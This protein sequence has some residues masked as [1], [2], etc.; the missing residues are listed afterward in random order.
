[1]SVAD[2]NP[3]CSSCHTPAAKS[4]PDKQ[5][6]LNWLSCLGKKRWCLSSVFIFFI[7]VHGFLSGFP[8]CFDLHCPPSLR[9]VCYFFCM[10]V[11][12]WYKRDLGA[13][14][15]NSLSE[16]HPPAHSRHSSQTLLTSDSAVA[17]A[18]NQQ[19]HFCS[20]WCASTISLWRMKVKPLS[21]EV[22]VYQEFWPDSTATTSSV[23][24]KKYCRKHKKLI[25][26]FPKVWSKQRQQNIIFLRFFL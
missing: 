16:W 11:S 26:A 6:H 7:C 18:S 22:I 5:D 15:H 3:L 19:W 9:L 25:L 21:L 12:R 13:S 23:V 4:S 8:S 2:S 20:P 10:P 1:M 24:C 17:E 14:P